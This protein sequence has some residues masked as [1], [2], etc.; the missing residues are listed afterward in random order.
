MFWIG[1]LTVCL[2]VAGA[3]IVYIM[4]HAL[5]MGFVRKIYDKNKP[6]GILTSFFPIVLCL[7]FLLVGWA[8]FIVALLHLAVI[9]MLCDLVGFI[10]R[11]LRHKEKRERYIT[12]FAAIAMT[13]AVLGCGW[14][15]AHH[16]FI[17]DYR[18]ST[19]KQ[20]GQD[21]LRVVMIADAHLGITLDGDEF[22]EQVKRI[23][24]Q[25]PDMV[26]ICGDFVDDES[27]LEDL[28]KACSALGSLKTSCGVYYCYGNHDRGYYDNRDFK[29]AD[30]V[31]CLEDNNVKI[32][33]D[34]SV[35]LGNIVIVG[36]EDK[37]QKVR[38]SASELT[39]DIDR[40][41]YIIMLDHQPNDYDAEASSGADLVLS[42]HTHG[43]HVFPAGPI[44]MLMGANDRIYGKEVRDNTTFI[45]TSGI[46]GWAIPFKTGT[47]SEIVVIDIEQK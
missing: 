9:W 35:D 31:K 11:K 14:F 7:P 47:L 23:Q 17:T 4:R 40:S 12:G 36:R 2:A 27:T 26:V 29:A 15:M 37:G 33:Q 6:L 21:S 25:D 39:K 46:S 8:A 5:R 19:S 42:G 44:G 32:L 20:L 24:E 22:A 38:S 1:L 45:V 16:I 13:A 43:G 34:K 3:G 28:K 30:L 18:L 10:I 41:K